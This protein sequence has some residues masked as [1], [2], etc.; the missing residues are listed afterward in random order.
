MDS[1]FGIIDA[2]AQKKID[3]SPLIK[4][5]PCNV[6]EV[7]ENGLVK[8]KT[9]S[10]GIEYSLSN[11]SGS[12]VA[13]GEN[14]FVYYKGNTL[15]SRTGYIGAADFK[16]ST[17]TVIGTAR[18]TTLTNAEKNI[19]KI[20]FTAYQP[21]VMLV[22]N[23]I[24]D[25]GDNSL[26][27]NC[28]FG[29]YVDG[30]LQL[31]RPQCSVLPNGSYHM[32]FVLPYS[33]SVGNHTITITGVGESISISALTAFV[34]GYV[35]EREGGYDPTYEEDYIWVSNNNKAE[36]LLYIGDSTS[37]EVAETL[38]DDEVKTLSCTSFNYS[39]IRAVYIPDGIE[40][41]E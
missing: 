14:V 24:C 26:V 20:E 40:R 7:L 36:L 25:N 38:N 4:S 18:L 37:P 12:P 41:I 16:S 1:L 6:S 30:V 19:S 8:V 9:L 5:L 31:Y 17:N 39:D 11:L 23:A 15:S 33:V 35:N 27:K 32:S 28:R 29:I 22:V 10:D 2:R 21:K 3:T 13:V 34:F